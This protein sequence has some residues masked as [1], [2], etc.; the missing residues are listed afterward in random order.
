MPTIKADGLTGEVGGGGFNFTTPAGKG[1]DGQNANCNWIDD[2]CAQVGG[3]GAPGVQGGQGGPGGPGGHGGVL[4]IEVESFSTLVTLSAN[5]GD[6]GKGGSGGKGQ[7]G[8]KGGKGGNGE[9]CELGR[10]GGNGGAGGA[11]GVGGQGGQGGNGGV[12]TV[13]FRTLADGGQATI[14][15]RAGFGGRGG[16]PGA[17]GLPGAP[18]DDGSTTGVFSTS[19]DCEDM[20]PVPAWG[21]TGGIPAPAS[22]G[23]GPSGVRGTGQFVQ[24]T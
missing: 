9:D 12:I 10:H 11:G 14:D 2:D 16:D 7:D 19:G 4:D 17:P 3:A 13:R 18:G 23:N 6:G 8:G 24:I 5:G 22:L 15:V 1:I 20:G 21:A